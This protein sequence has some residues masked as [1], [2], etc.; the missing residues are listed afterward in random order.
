MTWSAYA[1]LDRVPDALPPELHAVEV[2]A[3]VVLVVGP[4]PQRADPTI[5]A[6]RAHDSVVRAVAGAND[7]ILP[8]RFGARAETEAELVSSLR[9]RVAILRDGLVRVRDA[10]QVTLRVRGGPEEPPDPPPSGRGTGPG[11]RYLERRARALSPRIPGWE[12]LGRD[13]RAHARE[14][15]IERGDPRVERWRI[16]HLVTRSELSAHRAEAERLR[17]RGH[18]WKIVIGEPAPPWA[19]VPEE[20][21]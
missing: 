7:P 3:G 1:I 11:R 12:E 10:R 19:F 13:L 16:Y 6:L 4:A 20:M 5:E 17:E 18:G 9:P 21:R 2:E 8:M 14:E 15:K